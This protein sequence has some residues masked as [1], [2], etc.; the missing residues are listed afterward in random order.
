MTPENMLIFY[1]LLTK[2]KNP[3]I[4]EAT[5]VNEIRVNLCQI[6]YYSKKYFLLNITNTATNHNFNI[7]VT[8]NKTLSD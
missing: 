5:C 4:I 1:I 6:T 3:S 7:L 2:I 8:S